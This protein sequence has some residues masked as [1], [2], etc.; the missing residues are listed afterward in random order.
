MSVQASSLTLPE[1]IA[2]LRPFFIHPAIS[3]P[4]SLPTKDGDAKPPFVPIVCVSAS[5]FIDHGGPEHMRSRSGLGYEY[6]QGSG[7]DEDFWAQVSRRVW[8]RVMGLIHGTGFESRSV[9][10]ISGNAV[11]DAEAGFTRSD[12]AY[13]SICDGGQGQAQFDTSRCVDRGHTRLR[14]VS[15]RCVRHR[16]G[17]GAAVDTAFS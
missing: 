14:A 12:C 15:W 7:D 4:P 8:C 16:A 6:I 3:S 9:S 1:P 17:E 2:P 11:I 13:Q 10:S 5:E